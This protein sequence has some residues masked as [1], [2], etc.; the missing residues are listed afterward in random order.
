LVFKNKELH[1]GIILV[2][3]N[4]V[5]PFDKAIIVSENVK[6]YGE[7]LIDAFIVIYEKFVKTQKMNF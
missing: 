7:D 3:L 4:G 2:R 1:K 5:K 6:K